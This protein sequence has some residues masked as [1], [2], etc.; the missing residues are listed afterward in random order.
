MKLFYGSPDMSEKNTIELVFFYEGEKYQIFDPVP[1]LVPVPVPET[2][3]SSHP[4]FC[5]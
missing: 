3:F 1:V 4:Y 2:M 5:N